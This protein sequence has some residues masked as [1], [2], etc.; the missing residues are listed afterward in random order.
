[1]QTEQKKN[2]RSEEKIHKGCFANGKN[3]NGIKDFYFFD[4][5]FI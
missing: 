5:H 1:M 3:E 4:L 2:K